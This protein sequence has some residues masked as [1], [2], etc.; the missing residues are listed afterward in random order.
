MP[1]ILQSLI[2][3]SFGGPNGNF[4]AVLLEG[5]KLTH[6]FLDN[7][8]TSARWRRG[9]TIV[10]AGAAGPGSIIQSD[11]KRGVHGNFEVVVPLLSAAGGM[12]LWHFWHDS[13]DNSLPW[14]RTDMIAANVA[15]GASFIQGSLG[16][17][18]RGNFEL[19]V[20]LNT[21]SG[22]VELW[23]FWRDHSDA[24][25]P[26]RRGQR[27]TGDNDSVGGPGTIIQSDLGGAH[28]NFEVVVPL[29]TSGGATEL[30]HFW[31][32]N[33]SVAS[34]WQ[35][36]PRV[37]A[38]VAGPGSI[39]QSDFLS[40]DGRG[41]LDMVVPQGGSLIHYWRDG[42]AATSPWQRG[43]TVTDSAT[44][45]GCLTQSNFVSDGHGNLEVLVEECKQSVVYYSRANGRRGT[46]DWPWLR[47][48]FLLGEPEPR[49][50][51]GTEKVVQLTGQFDRQGWN[52]E[53]TPPFAH[54][55]TESAFGVRGTDLGAS[56]VHKNRVYFLFGDT[57]RAGGAHP[58]LD[59]IAWSADADASDGIRLTFNAEPPI[60][61]RPPIPQGGFEV[62]VDGVSV[63][64]RMYVF[65]TTDHYQAG[66]R[67]QMGRCVLT[68][69]NDDGL[70][71]DNLYTFSTSKF[72][73]VSVET[74]RL[75]PPTANQL[76][77]PRDTEV[78]WIWGS[79]RYRSSD[80]YLAVMPLAN[81]ATGRGVK[82]YTGRRP[83]QWGT[84]E[85]EAAALFCAGSVGELSVRW[86]PTLKRYLAL[87]NGTN[88]R[89][90]VMHSAKKPQGP[91]SSD[92]VMVFDSTFGI[93]PERPCAGA[94]YGKFIHVS[95]ADHR[96][97]HVQDDMFEPGV[98]RDNDYGGEYGPY[99]I[100]RYAEAVRGGGAR[101]YFTMS[102]WNPYQVVLMRAVIPKDAV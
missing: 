29:I 91:W 28:G 47:N 66:T 84:S 12:Q 100:T 95:W 43:Q 83:S 17:G 40:G 45:W 1:K 3:S 14:Q 30:R 26:W 102:T 61:R 92:P 96:C 63:N 16:G 60:V 78:L 90:I 82:Y 42:S 10:A 5:D 88:P 46:V 72:I 77:L 73:N 98:F 58:G 25:L 22:R 32:D 71:F 20:P 87:F 59:A 64:N 36:G 7:T 52:G 56:F 19:V 4:E 70:N 67:N 39:I 53:G 35:R 81:I 6:W 97:D 94:G 62:P 38:N 57:F 48:R 2:Q 41:R 11:F 31:H 65:F 80:V 50:L 13:F 86:N 49:R 69:S 27:V 76:G 99:Q 89:G 33:S 51:A 54:N 85:D 93:T 37:A 8:V 18:Q 75:D 74:G 68:R 21:E 44:G 34:P 23:H 79:G 24:R 9:H 55:K 15:G 101:I